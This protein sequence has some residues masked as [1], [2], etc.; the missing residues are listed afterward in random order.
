MADIKVKDLVIH[1][2]S[3]HNLFD[4]SES[5]MMEITD[6][7]E[8]QILGGQRCTMTCLQVTGVCG[9]YPTERGD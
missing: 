6:E 9:H 8:H 4:D 5:F 3:G 2:I 1:N 7:Q